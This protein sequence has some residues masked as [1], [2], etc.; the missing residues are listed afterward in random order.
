MSEGARILLAV[1]IFGSTLAAGHALVY[2]RDPRS[3]WGWIAVCLMFPMA[4]AILYYFFGINRVRQRATRLQALSPFALQGADDDQCGGC[5]HPAAGH[6]ILPEFAEMARLSF[7]ITGR[8]LVRG[9]EVVPLVNGEEAF[10]A[11]LRAIEQARESVCLCTYIFETNRAGMAFIEALISAH[12][13]GVEV[14]VIVD[15]VGQW[16]SRPRASVLL[17]RAGV[18]TAVF[19]PPSLIP[20]SFSVNLRNHRK[21]LIVDGRVG[22][23]GGMNIG[24]RHLVNDPTVTRPNQDLHFCLKGPV[25]TQL[26]EAFRWD[27]GFITGEETRPPEPKAEPVGD[28]LCRTVI[29]GPAGP[30]ERL[31]II[32]TGAVS[33]ARERVFI[34]CPY[35]LP[36]RELMGALRAAALRGV[37]VC[38]ILPSRNNLPYVHWAMRNMLWEPLLDGVEVRYQ[39]PPFAHTKLFIMDRHYALVGSTN[40]DPRSLR[41]NFELGVEIYH[42][43]TV[44]RLTEHF[45]KIRAKSRQTTL[46]EV[47]GRNLLTRLRDSA[48]W[49]FSPY[50]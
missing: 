42:Q 30:L 50:M 19:L 38:V 10:P 2:K 5:S 4:G 37:E 20:L 14:K 46:E 35:F 43:A 34:M 49:L 27:W 31:S 13:R 7:A 16:Y 48:F 22:F 3:A 47:D 33:L 6:L 40:I 8:P 45:Q 32:M 28:A 18:P 36:P 26:E 1:L 39:P 15:G 9:N 24:D 11:M 17:R 23:C 41:L 12:R 21:S 29:D 25:V 44:A